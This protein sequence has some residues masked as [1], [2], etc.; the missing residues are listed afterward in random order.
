MIRDRD[1]SVADNDEPFDI[2]QLMEILWRSKTV[3]ILG[4]LSFI[5]VAYLIW[6]WLPSQYRNTIEV[7]TLLPGEIPS[8]NNHNSLGLLSNK[9]EGYLF[10]LYMRF[11]TDTKIKEAV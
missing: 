11:I 8:L 2:Y 5:V 6:M 7:R 3:I 4:T 10:N 1:L 9:T